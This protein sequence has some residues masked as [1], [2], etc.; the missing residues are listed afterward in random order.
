MNIIIVGDNSLNNDYH[1]LLSENGFAS[2]INAYT[3]IPKFQNHSCIDHIFVHNNYASK[4]N[5]ITY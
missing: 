5:Y 1:N 2:F 3:R 4:C